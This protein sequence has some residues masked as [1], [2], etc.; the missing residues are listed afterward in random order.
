M[1]RCLLR[2]AIAAFK[3]IGEVELASYFLQ[4]PVIG[5]TGSNGKTTTTALTG[6]IS[7]GMRH[8]GAGRREY[9]NCGNVTCW[10]RRKPGQWNVLE[11]SS[12]QLESIDTFPGGDCRVSECHA[13][14]PG[15]SSHIGELRGGKAAVVRD[16]GSD[17]EH[18]VLNCERPSVP[19]LREAYSAHMCT[20]SV[21]RTVR[22]M[23]SMVHA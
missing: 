7:E 20:G 13:G 22:G 23:C 1:R 4:G 2:P 18:A 16:P 5:I 12:F 6:H 8:S 17:R 10:L 21:R 15:P 14:S 11:L 9:R 19:R 3:V